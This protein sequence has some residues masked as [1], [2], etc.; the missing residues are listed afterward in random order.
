[1]KANLNEAARTRGPSR[2]PS[3][4]QKLPPIRTTQ[5]AHH[6]GRDRGA[7]SAGDPIET[8]C[9]PSIQPADRGTLEGLWDPRSVGN[10]GDANIGLQQRN[11]ISLARYL[12]AMIHLHAV[13]AQGRVQSR[14]AFAIATRQQLFRAQ[15]VDFNAVMSGEPVVSADDE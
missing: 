11:E 15:I 7:F 4:V 12:M 14:G 5:H 2:G 13:F 3:L 9:A 1:M 6:G 10:E 8:D